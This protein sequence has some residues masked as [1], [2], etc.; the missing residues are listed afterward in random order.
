VVNR[1]GI[2]LGLAA[3]LAL[4]GAAAAAFAGSTTS[5][6]A[7]VRVTEREYRI[8]LSTKTLPAGTVVLVVY[9]AG[10]L[11]HRLS[12][13]GPGLTTKTT[14]A[15]A[16]GAT[17]SLTVKLGGGAFSLWCPIAS[18]AALGMKATLTLRGPAVGGTPT[19]PA[20]MPTDPGYDGGDGY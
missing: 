5:R 17:R 15:I 4:G 8:S 11:A 16:P 18:H 2:A 13:S 6:A 20:P 7:T 10:K 14:P 19:T 1:I 9:N 3:A 12:I